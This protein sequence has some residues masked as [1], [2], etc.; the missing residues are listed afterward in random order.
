MKLYPFKNCVLRVFPGYCET[1][2]RDET[3]AP[4]AP[5]HTS[6][7]YR[8]TALALG[9]SDDLAGLRLMSFEHEALH[10]V[11]AEAEG[12]LYSRVLWDVAH[13]K[14]DDGTHAE[15]EHTVLSVQRLLCGLRKDA[16]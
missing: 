13:G 5:Q 6:D 10:T 12:W 2:F 8:E 1:R 4:A 9:Y 7:A 15:E 16:A 14:P 3:F 11:L